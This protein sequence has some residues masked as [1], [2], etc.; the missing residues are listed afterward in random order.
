MSASAFLWFAALAAPAE[1]PD[2]IGAILAREGPVARRLIASH[3]Q[4]KEAWRESFWADALLRAPPSRDPRYRIHDLN[5]PQ[6]PRVRPAMRECSG[7]AAPARAVRLFDGTGTSAFTGPR[8]AFWRADSALTASAREPNRITTRADFGRVRVHLEFRTPEPARG[9]FQ[10]R[11]NSGV[12]LM[13]RYEIQILDG[14]DNPTYPDGMAGALYGQAPPRA[15]ASLPPGRWQCLDILFT[16]PRFAGERLV[17]PAR[18]SVW[19]NH[20]LVQNNAAF[21]GPT[22]FASV[23][24]YAA[25]PD[26]LPIQLQDHGD[27]TSMVSF[28]NIWALP[29]DGAAE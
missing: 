4:M 9:V 18:V 24:P 5:R 16:P 26:R 25:H 8:L 20:V 7:P 23:R 17:R 13:E 2:Q 11:G 29:L 12:F 28:R 3:P 27:G 19:H 1:T 14:F 22:A 15:N 6:P 10:Y 21:A